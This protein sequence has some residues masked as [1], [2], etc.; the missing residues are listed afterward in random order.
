MRALVHDAYVA[1]H[2]GARRCRTAIDALLADPAPETLAAARAGLAR[3]RGRPTCA[4][5]AFQFYAGPVDGAGGP[6]P[7]LNAWPIDP[8][9]LDYV[10]GTRCG[11]VDD[12]SVAARTAAAVVAARTRRRDPTEVTTG[13]H[14]IEF[15][16]WGEDRSAAGPGARPTPTSSPA[17]ATTT[18]AATIS[19]I[20]TAAPGQRPRRRWSPPGRPDTN[21]YRALVE[22]MDQRNA[23][24]RAFNGMTVLAGYEIALR[25]IGAGLCRGDANFQQSPFSDTSAADNRHAFEGARDVYFGWRAQ[26]PASTRCSPASTRRST[27]ASPPPST[28]PKQRVAALDAPYDRF[29]A[30]PAGSPS[31][32]RPRPRCRAHRPRPRAP[33]GRQPAR[34]PR[35][36]PRGLTP[37]E[38]RN[39]FLPAATPD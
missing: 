23:I 14:A 33:R 25:G 5:E 2:D 28:A 8:A 6:L 26:A 21:N 31:A 29:L 10:E 39:R 17:R 32:P 1:A 15:L 9:F 7:R 4:T 22:A 38:R 35:R 18:A 27:T 34:R 37:A 20:V 3:R 30:P 16:L 36:R 12:P 13:W 19:R 24:G 11:I